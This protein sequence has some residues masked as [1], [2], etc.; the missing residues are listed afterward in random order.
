[1]R[2]YIVLR[3]AEALLRELA[4]AQLGL[5]VAGIRNLTPIL[6]GRL[7]V[8]GLVGGE[9]R[10]VVRLGEPVLESLLVN[11]GCVRPCLGVLCG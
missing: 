8:F 10:L 9:S 11:E 1:M 6:E 7:V 2:L 3:D 4:E 5:G